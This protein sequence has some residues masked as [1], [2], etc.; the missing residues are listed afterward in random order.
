MGGAIA[1]ASTALLL[2][3]RLPHLRV[4]IVEK[5]TEFDWKVG[6]S[7]VEVSAYFLTRELRLAEYLIREHLQKQS[8]RFWFHH[9]EVRSLP[10]ASEVG[11][12]QL[13]RTPAFQLDRSKLDEHVLQRAV[14]EG[15]ELWRPAR[16]V[17]FALAEDTGQADNTLLVERGG[18]R[19][20]VRARWLV[21]ASGRSAMI[22]R[23]KQMLHPLREHPTAAIWARFRG[24]RDLEGPEI[25]GTDPANP[26]LR[27]VLA[28]RWLATNHFTGWGYWIWFIPLRGGE[29]SIGLVWDQRLVEPQ[30]AHPQEKLLRFLQDNP[31]TRQL[32]EGAE[33]VPG[34]VRQFGHL[35]YL[36]DRAAGVGWSLV[37]DAAGFL[38]PF[39]SP[40]LDQMGFSARWTVELIRQ[41]EKMGDG[42]SF[43]RFVAEHSRA[44]TRYFRLLFEGIYRDKYYLMG[45]YDTMTAAFLLDTSLYYLVEAIPLYR[46]SADRMLVPPFYQKYSEIAL[47]PIRFYQR[48]LVSIA[49]RKRK[50]GIYGARNAGRRP[51]LVGFSV[52]SA[53][54]LM[55]A[56]GLGYYLRA[57]AENALSYLIR[58]KPMIPR[59]PIPAEPQR[60]AAAPNPT[61]EIIIGS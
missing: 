13:A 27:S 38:D 31:L 35:P 5:K 18:R 4:L 42:E 43:A 50:L 39:Y 11:P 40:G 61:A 56:R 36:V 24:V 33:V 41:R 30:G 7:T 21:D 26:Y 12:Y 16:V 9:G 45:D 8:F 15:A 44:Y 10:E 20:E 60:R 57:E 54:W 14:Q 37:G 29:T 17:S 58:P 32:I 23:A 59:M 22:A 48:R 6:E 2:R 19:V 46:W 47:R 3:R 25:C 55:F 28:P 53:V 34:D 52:R 51:R 1:G 49:R